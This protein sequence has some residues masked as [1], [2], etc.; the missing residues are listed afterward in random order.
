MFRAA[1][2]YAYLIHLGFLLALSASSQ[3]V[4]RVRQHEMHSLYLAPFISTPSHGQLLPGI[5]LRIIPLKTE[6][7]GIANSHPY[8]YPNPD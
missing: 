6:G 5:I 7:G 4:K 1:S 8:L 3:M 2:N